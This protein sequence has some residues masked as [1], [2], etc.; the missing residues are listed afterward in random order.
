MKWILIEAVFFGASALMLDA[1]F[2]HGLHNFL[3]SQFTD[4][5][6]QALTT[7]S[8]YQ[9]KASILLIVTILLYRSI[10]SLWVIASQLLITSGVL[11]FCVSIYLRHLFGYTCFANL[12]PIGGI[13]FML[14]FL[15]LLP[16]ILWL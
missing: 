9:L 3:G 12:A 4:T 11:F 1:F 2:A 5:I 15:A 16:L 13:S 7:A 14:S 8:R 10:P 6:H